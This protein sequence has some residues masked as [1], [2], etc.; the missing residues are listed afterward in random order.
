MLAGKTTVS[1]V[2]SLARV[3]RRIA[4]TVEQWDSDPWLLNT[5][6]VVVDLRSGKQR[7]HD[8][9]DYFTK[10][11]AV[12]PDPSCPIPLW[13]AFLD[14]VC[15]GDVEFVDFLQRAVGYGLTGVTREHALFFCYE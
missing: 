1:A 2:V 9:S 6:S 15:M 5:P 10:I 11:T 8:P 12:A 4:A 13:L 3:D 14:R 7:S